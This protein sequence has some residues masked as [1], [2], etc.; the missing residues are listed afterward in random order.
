MLFISKLWNDYIKTKEELNHAFEIITLY[1]KDILNHKLN[2]KI[3]IFNDYIDNIEIISQNNSTKEICDK[4]N[5]IV[6]LKN[7]IKYNANANLLMDKLII[8]LE[9]V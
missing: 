8:S 1:Y 4:I 2:R 6:N 9:E 5:I 7:K 3:E